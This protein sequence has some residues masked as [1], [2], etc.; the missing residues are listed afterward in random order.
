MGIL[1][2]MAVITRLK[3]NGGSREEIAAAASEARSQVRLQEQRR[4]AEAV[5]LPEV[6]ASPS[7]RS[8]FHSRSVVI[9]AA[10][11]TATVSLSYSFDYT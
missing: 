4:S 2:S 9:W 5:G 10:A 3:A 7:P 11:A 1:E 8:R 6:F